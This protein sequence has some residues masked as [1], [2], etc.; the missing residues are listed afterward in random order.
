VVATLRRYNSSSHA[1]IRPRGR[2]EGK[3]PRE[4]VELIRSFPKKVFWREKKVIS[5]SVIA[6]AAN[7]TTRIPSSHFMMNGESLLALL[8]FARGPHT[9]SRRARANTPCPRRLLRR[10]R[11]LSPL[12]PSA[13]PFRFSPAKKRAH[14][15]KPTSSATSH[16]RQGKEREA[17]W[18]SDKCYTHSSKHLSLMLNAGYQRILT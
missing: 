15:P 5:P 11:C 16:G 8:L 4:K 1:F 10:L 9:C 14:F 2:R 17:R 7:R 13:S 6:A 3:W 18:K 12:S